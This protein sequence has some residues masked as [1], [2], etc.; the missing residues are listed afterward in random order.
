[1]LV[2]HC[3]HTTETVTQTRLKLMKNLTIQ[4]Y[5]FI[6][7]FYLIHTWNIS[8]TTGTSTQITQ[9]AA[10]ITMYSVR[11]STCI[12]NDLYYIRNVYKNYMFTGQEQ[13]YISDQC[14]EF[15]YHQ[16]IKKGWG[17]SVALYLDISVLWANLGH[18][19][20]AV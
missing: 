17:H 3:W 14:L 10:M 7:I 13:V 5:I 16:S 8:V 2:L 6:Y 20:I 19:W 12:H 15:L 4:I 1:M 11:Q 18:V 9:S